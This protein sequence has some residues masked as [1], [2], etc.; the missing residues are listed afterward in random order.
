MI[1]CICTQANDKEVRAKASVLLQKATRPVG[2]T[3][4]VA[5]H[6]VLEKGK[7]QCGKRCGQCLPAVASILKEETEKAGDTFVVEA[8]SRGPLIEAFKEQQ[9]K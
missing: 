7:P 3:H 4:V 9:K 5:L 8:L 2:I 6:K 1:V